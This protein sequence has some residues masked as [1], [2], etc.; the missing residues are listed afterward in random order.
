MATFPTLA[1]GDR[2]DRVRLVLGDNEVHIFKR[3][4]V[5]KRYLQVPSVFSFVVGSGNTAR[6]LMARF[7]PN[8]P[9]RVL[10]GPELVQFQG[11]TDG[12]AP[13]NAQGATELMIRGRDHLAALVDGHID[14]DK[15]FTNATFH[16]LAIKG[17]EGSGVKGYRL[18]TSREATRNAVTGTP[19][20]EDVEQEARIQ[21]LFPFVGAENAI[22]K[23]N[24]A[25]PFNIEPPTIT[26]QKI[27]GYRTA[28]PIKAKAGETWYAFTKKN[29]DRAG[30]FLHGGVDPEGRTKVFVLSEPNAKQPPVAMLVRQRGSPTNQNAVNILSHRHKHEIQGRHLTY[31][32]QGR[33]SN[34]ANGRHRVEGRF[35]DEE[36]AALGFVYPQKTFVAVN[37]EV[38]S[39]EHA[40]YMARRL[41]AEAHRTGWTIIYVVKGH[42]AP[43]LGDLTQR[44]VWDIDTVVRVHDEELGIEGDFWVEGVCFRCDGGSGTTTELTLMRPEDLVFGEGEFYSP[45]GAK[46]KHGGRGRGVVLDKNPTP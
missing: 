37:D 26:V 6:D 16:D 2:D 45:G 19:I 38:K 34:G 41:C 14:A 42:S 27:T 13:D 20:I 1:N 25:A 12:Y 3:Y 46:K 39:Q 33:A 28:T 7:P 36:M 29:F 24:N 44:T 4:E 5:Q 11:S 30:L 8:S 35:V 32:V 31:I 23:A 17:I 15:N 40:E 10:V 18:E 9:F 21:D 22:G 43:F